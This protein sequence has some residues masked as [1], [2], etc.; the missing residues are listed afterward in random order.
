MQEICVCVFVMMPRHITIIIVCQ[1]N[2]ESSSM[3][4]IGHR[5]QT[6]CNPQWTKSFLDAMIKILRTLQFSH[7]NPRE[8]T[9]SL[10]KT[11]PKTNQDNPGH[12][13]RWTSGTK[14]T[15]GVVL[16]HG[17]IVPHLSKCL[18]QATHARPLGMPAHHLC[19]L[20]MRLWA[21]V[22]VSQEPAGRQMWYRVHVVRHLHRTAQ[23]Q[24]FHGQLSVTNVNNCKPAPES[25]AHWPFSSGMLLPKLRCPH[26]VRAVCCEWGKIYKLLEWKNM[27]H[28]PPKKN[29]RQ[30]AS[31][32][33]T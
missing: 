17:C 15:G 7:R 9:M 1:H 32:R 14:A 3:Q 22:A 29:K 16:Q 33:T 28:N 20:H 30:R 21:C 19:S 8:R 23:S 12:D 6:N 5:M 31:N 10:A 18:V 24:R 27:Q 4:Q 11:C 2:C 26:L 13:L 25:M